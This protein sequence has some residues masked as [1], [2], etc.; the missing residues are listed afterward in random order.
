MRCWVYV[1]PSKNQ[2]NYLHQFF[3]VVKNFAV[4]CC[5]LGRIKLATLAPKNKKAPYLML[6]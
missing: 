3:P 6:D 2:E 4:F 5:Y 1:K